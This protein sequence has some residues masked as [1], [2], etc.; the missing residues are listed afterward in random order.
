MLKKNIL[1]YCLCHIG[2][3]F[4]LHSIRR[5]QISNRFNWSDGGGVWSASES[6]SLRRRCGCDINGKKFLLR[7]N[8]VHVLA[9]ASFYY[10]YNI[11]KCVRVMREAE[12]VS[13]S[14]SW[15]RF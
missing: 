1:D 10:I 15:A 5:Y 9:N 4:I 11:D 7:H 12:C 13:V 2:P 3:L 14:L 8:C 6:S